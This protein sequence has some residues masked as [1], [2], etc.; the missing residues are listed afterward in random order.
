MRI[1]IG[2]PHQE[3]QDIAITPRLEYLISRHV[4]DFLV[5]VLLDIL[6]SLSGVMQ[7]TDIHWRVK[8]GMQQNFGSQRLYCSGSCWLAVDA[9]SSVS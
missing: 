7:V 4:V 3:C 6:L 5:H 2:Y 9:S 8:L 1:T